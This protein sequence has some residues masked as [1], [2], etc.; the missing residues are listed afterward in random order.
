[1]PEGDINPKVVLEKVAEV[2]GV[3]TEDM[4]Q[5]PQTRG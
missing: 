2:F 3:S 1:M 4:Q 5:Q